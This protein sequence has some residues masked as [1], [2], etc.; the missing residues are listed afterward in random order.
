MHR[1]DFADADANLVL[2]EPRTL[3]PNNRLV[4]HLD[5]RGKKKIP[6]RPSACLKYFR[7]HDDTVI[8]KGVLI[9]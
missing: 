1:G 3:V 2:A 5:D 4:R 9:N 6:A 7:S 8:Q